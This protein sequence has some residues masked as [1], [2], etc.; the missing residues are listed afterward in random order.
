MFLPPYIM[1]S[2]RK[3]VIPLFKVSPMCYHTRSMTKMSEQLKIAHMMN[4]LP[5]RLEKFFYSTE[6]HKLRQG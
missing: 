3:L 6:K 1:H 4:Q 2:I 5:H